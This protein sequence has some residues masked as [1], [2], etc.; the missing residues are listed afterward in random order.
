MRTLIDW[1]LLPIIKC[2]HAIRDIFTIY[3]KGDEKGGV[4]GG[5]KGGV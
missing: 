4:E 5:V 3:R 2:P 1:S